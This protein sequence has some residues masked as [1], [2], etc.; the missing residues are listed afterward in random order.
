MPSPVNLAIPSALTFAFRAFQR[1]VK[2]LGSMRWVFNSWLRQSSLQSQLLSP[3]HYWRALHLSRPQ[4]SRKSNTPPSPSHHSP[5]SEPMSF[6]LWMD[7][8]FLL[9][10]LQA[11]KFSV[12]FGTL[13]YSPAELRKTMPC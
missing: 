4:L 7:S 1:R 11:R 12:R 10:A 13:R 6:M 9:L 8:A 5:I 2:D 3:R